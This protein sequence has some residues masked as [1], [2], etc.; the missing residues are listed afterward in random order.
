ML[1]HKWDWYHIFISLIYCSTYTL[2]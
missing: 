1:L 2:T